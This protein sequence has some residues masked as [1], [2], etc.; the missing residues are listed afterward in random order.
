M[1]N[2][3]LFSVLLFHIMLITITAKA[4]TTCYIF[5]SYDN[6]GYR[7]NRQYQCITGP[8]SNYQGGPVMRQAHGTGTALGNDSIITNT[9]SLYPNPSNGHFSAV[10][11]YPVHD[12]DVY[13][14]DAKGAVISRK[15][16]D[17]TETS[18]DIS[19]YPPGIYVL[20]LKSKD[21]EFEAKV[22]KE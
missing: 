18:F 19:Q 5:Y 16:M 4:Q 2:I 6:A 17:G 7:I 14:A 10:L 20:H 8:N 12:A 11:K 13:I 15:K 3:V 22:V 21:Y 9:C 1:K